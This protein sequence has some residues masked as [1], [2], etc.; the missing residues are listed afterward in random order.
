MNKALIAL[1][2]SYSLICVLCLGGTPEC[3]AQQSSSLTIVAPANNSEV[4][5]GDIV[6]VLVDVA[7][8]ASFPKGVAVI[9]ADPIEDSDI[10]RVPPYRFSLSIPMTI[11]CGRYQLTAV[12]TDSSG[13]TIFS[14]PITL[15]V[16]PTE[17][18]VALRTDPLQL[19]FETSGKEAQV[20]VIA[21]LGDNS[22]MDVTES[23][24]MSYS[25]DD[26]S[27]A[28]ST[29][30]GL[31]TAKA[32]GSAFVTAQ[33]DVFSSGPSA[34]IPVSVLAPFPGFIVRTPP[35]TTSAVSPTPNPAGWNNSNVSISL[36]ST[37]NS[38]SGIKRISYSATGAQA[39]LTTIIP[40]SAASALI[41]TEGI[42]NFSFFATDL[43]GNVE[44]AHSLVI[45]LDKTPPSITGSRSP[46][47]N[48]N[49]W[50]N[51]D[52]TV[53]FA[54]S[55]A[56]SRLAPG[57]PP[58]STL[59]LSEGVNQQVPGACLDLAD[60]AASAT[61][62]G[63]NIDKTPPTI[64]PS[65]TPA[66][67]ANGWNNTNVTVSFAC[68]DSLSGLA[69][70]SPPA[71]TILSTEGTNQQVSGTCLDL[72]GNSASAA[73]SGINIDK[74]QPVVSGLPAANC[75][76]WPPNHKFVTVA[77]I[78]GADLLSGLASFSVTG[79][80]NEPQNPN[81]P[82]IIITGTGLGPRT[83]QLR[84]D[85]LGT[86]TGRVYTLTTAATDAAGNLVNTTSTCLVPHDQAP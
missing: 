17:T 15:D 75:K 71:P 64:T 26:S 86:G 67:N 24:K 83:V 32:P 21:V 6:F 76:L 39:I 51:M 48:A 4:H 2:L 36:S 50:S 20:R 11:G 69:P 40:G 25:I 27:I 53:S 58:G 59:V 8:N 70:G 66:A 37:D 41:S 45:Q 72:A 23:L 43:A 35:S 63:I 54:C 68:V 18:P 55:D 47:A 46:A 85:R 77:T 80:S 74:T 14:E 29:G 42:T 52:V 57:S 13:K 62:S 10:E 19:Q 22:T 28:A 3:I 65:R 33:F 84:A 56:L 9:A 60:N 79:T 12:G 34:T 81:D 38:G 49:G 31:I 61:V 1:F 78:S 5:P 73:A 16:E 30:N 82:D 44:A 7:A